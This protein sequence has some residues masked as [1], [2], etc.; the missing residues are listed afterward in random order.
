MKLLFTL[1][2]SCFLMSSLVAQQTVL[3]GKITDEETGEELI[4]ANITLYQNGHVVCGASTD[5]EGNYSIKTN[6]GVYDLE[7]SYIGYE[8]QKVR[9]VDVQNNL[10][11]DVKVTTPK[12]GLDLDKIV[13]RCCYCTIPGINVDEDIVVPKPVE[14]TPIPQRPKETL[15]GGNV[16]GDES[17]EALAGVNVSV[18]QND[19]VIAGTST[20]AK[21]KY[22]LE[23]LPGKYEVVFSY[24]G[25]EENAMPLNVSA[26][27]GVIAS[28]I[29]RMK[30][31]IALDEVLIIGEKLMFIKE[32]IISCGGPVEGT[33]CFHWDG[34]EQEEADSRNEELE[35]IEDKALELNCYPNPTIS[36]LHVYLEQAVDQLIIFNL[37]G[38]K[39]LQLNKVE[40]GIVQLDLSNYVAGSYLIKVV[41]GKE[42][43]TKKFV[44]AKK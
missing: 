2:T 19:E 20:D 38:K 42:A 11:H 29:V 17:N 31:G 44:V 15:L 27:V 1:I 40:A 5:F 25:Y 9:S 39:L 18:Y 22:S 23:L 43:V 30:K 36:T 3:Q 8:T 16:V 10:R 4:G 33:H 28:Q 7:V 24:V 21:G 14:Q 32:C 6:P 12:G 35:I 13:V 34:E 37:T 41:K 26:K